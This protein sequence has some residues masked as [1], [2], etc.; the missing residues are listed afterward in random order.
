[1]LNTLSLSIFVYINR[2]VIAPEAQLAQLVE[3]FTGEPCNFIMKFMKRNIWLIKIFA[4]FYDNVYIIKIPDSIIGVS[5][6]RSK[7]YV[8][9]QVN[10]FFWQWVFFNHIT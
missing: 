7:F 1:M 8:H 10:H 2:Y 5:L 9:L 6:P 3:L 4:G